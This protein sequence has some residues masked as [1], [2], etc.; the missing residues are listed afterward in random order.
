MLSIPPF[1]VWSLICLYIRLFDSPLACFI[2]LFSFFYTRCCQPIPLPLGKG[3]GKGKGKARSSRKK[4]KKRRKGKAEATGDEDPDDEGQK[5][6]S[7]SSV[8]DFVGVQVS[9]LFFSPFKKII[10]GAQ[11]RE[12]SFFFFFT[13]LESV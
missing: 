12:G 1:C 3:K 4:K 9:V 8:S 11:A 5:A 6:L 10:I 7:P 2:G 13:L